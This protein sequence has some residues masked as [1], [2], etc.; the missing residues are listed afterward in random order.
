VTPGVLLALAA[1]CRNMEQLDLLGCG[2][3][4]GDDARAILRLWS[5]LRLLDLSFCRQIS[6]AV[7]VELQQEFP[8]VDIKRSFSS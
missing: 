6:S 1:G 8:R 4:T 7:H 2:S 3:I 5:H